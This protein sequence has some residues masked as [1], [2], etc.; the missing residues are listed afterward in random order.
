MEREELATIYAKIDLLGGTQ[1]D[2]LLIE[3]LADIT[4]G[5]YTKLIDAFWSADHIN[6]GRLLDSFPELSSIA[7]YKNI[8]GYWED[9]KKKF[10][11]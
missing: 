1:A 8:S 11:V 4:G 7:K 3:Y 10:G 2:K 6:Q 5:F 9:F